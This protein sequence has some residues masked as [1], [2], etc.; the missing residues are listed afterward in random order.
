MEKEGESAT[1]AGGGAFDFSTFGTGESAVTPK[2]KEKKPGVVQSI[3]RTVAS[4]V[5]KTLASG[6]AMINA[7]DKEDYDR[8]QKEGVSFGEY[9]GKAKPVGAG[10][11]VTKG[12][13]ENIR[14]LA[15]AAGTG[16]EVASYIAPVGKLKTGY[17][18]IKG[19]RIAKGAIE[20]AKA[21]SIAGGIGGTG[22]ELQDPNATVGS[23]AGAGVA[24]SLIGGATGGA[25]GGGAGAVSNK[26][27]R[28]VA[29]RSP[30]AIEKKMDDLVGMIVQGNKA[31]I[32]KAKQALSNIDIEGIKTF[33]DL[34]ARAN[35]QVET[36]A[37]K[38]SEGLQSDTRLFKLKDLAAEAKVG[39]QVVK[40]NYVED[41]INHLEELYSKTTDPVSLAKIRQLKAR[42]KN[43]G[44]TIDEVNKL[45][46]EHGKEFGSKAFSKATGEPLTSVNAQ[47]FESVRKGIKATARDRFD[48]E[49]YKAADDEISKLINLRSLA[50]DMAEAA[51]KLQQKIK[52]RTLGQKIGGL[53][54]KAMDLASGGMLKGATSY[55][56]PRG[57][58]LKV[59][60][61][62]DLEKA[63]SKNLAR[64]K[65][66]ADQDLPD[67]TIIEQLEAMVPGKLPVIDFGGKGKAP[68]KSIPTIQF[69]PPKRRAPLPKKP[70]PL[71]KKK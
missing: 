7:G 45:A 1:P 70:T 56:L 11:D 22:S 4:P 32:P 62:L 41:A 20:G 25:L 58:G 51:N 39:D 28:I 64:F 34:A 10:F 69:N 65:A 55:F 36:I 53:I 29:S 43:S 24:G 23:V 66:L 21:G 33:D 46:I 15:D 3:V 17:D 26:A 27:S 57:E 12:L 31:D 2:K 49:L 35:D 14:P 48:N 16:L 47:S 19:G 67:A 52:N 63:L 60:N 6:A 71:K 68:S 40:H 61:A 13:K 18:A 59:L 37:N 50:K 42:A 54:A 30:Q 5:L 9:L 38:L 44:L 8:I